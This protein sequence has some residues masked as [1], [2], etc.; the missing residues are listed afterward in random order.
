VDI[1]VC[2][3]MPVV[4][5]TCVLFRVSWDVF[6][7]VRTTWDVLYSVHNYI[8]IAAIM[9]AWCVVRKLCDCDRQSSVE[10]L[11]CALLRGFWYSEQKCES[12]IAL[13]DGYRHCEQE[14]SK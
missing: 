10:L 4:S 7:V 13:F 1:E 12:N 3:C 9:D 6:S 14:R 2:L 8:H 5:M 11:L